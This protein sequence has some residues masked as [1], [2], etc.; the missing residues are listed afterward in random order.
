LNI[1]LAYFTES[2]IQPQWTKGVFIFE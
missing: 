2:N 1:N